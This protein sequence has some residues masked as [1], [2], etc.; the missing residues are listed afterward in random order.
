MSPVSWRVALSLVPVSFRAFLLHILLFIPSFL[1]CILPF[2]RSTEQVFV[3]RYD[4]IIP[5][6][7]S[8]VLCRIASSTACLSSSTSPPLTP[9]SKFGRLSSCSAT[10]LSQPISTAPIPRCNKQLPRR[11]WSRPPRLLLFSSH[12]HARSSSPNLD[13]QRLSFLQHSCLPCVGGVAR[14]LEPL[15]KLRR[16]TLPLQL[17]SAPS[18]TSALIIRAIQYEATASA[19]V[20]LPLA[21][22]D[23]PFT[24]Y[25]YCITISTNP[26]SKLVREVR[27]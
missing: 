6:C 2:P 24:R 19:R 23:P 27:D 1:F 10:D 7:S 3:C 15:C 21:P 25:R 26:S 17:T 13:L 16:A 18:A 4:Y 20:P 22:A 11:D 14:G 12:T 9:I 5:S 8:D